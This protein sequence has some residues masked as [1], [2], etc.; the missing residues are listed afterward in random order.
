MKRI[1]YVVFGLALSLAASAGLADSIEDSVKDLRIVCEG[2]LYYVPVKLSLNL[3]FTTTDGFI[4]ASE[5]DSD[6][7]W[8]GGKEVEFSWSQTE[9]E[10]SSSLLVKSEDLSKF[11]AGETAKLAGTFASSEPDGE[12]KLLVDCTKVETK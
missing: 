8:D 5:R 6:N 11:L 4:G 2:E 12:L 1:E 3:G 10:D 7:A 9:C